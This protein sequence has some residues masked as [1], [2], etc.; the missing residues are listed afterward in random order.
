MTIQEVKSDLV[1]QYNKPDHPFWAKVGNF[2]AIIGGP[3]GALA[4]FIFVPAPYKEPAAAAWAAIMGAIKG[5]TK[6]TS[7]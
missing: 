7:N 4:I 2:C 1:K 3:V 6:L 5:A